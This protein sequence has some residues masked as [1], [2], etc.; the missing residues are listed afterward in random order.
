M[1]FLMNRFCSV[2]SHHS[3]L[4][5]RRSAHPANANGIWCLPSQIPTYVMIKGWSNRIYMQNWL[6]TDLLFLPK[7]HFSVNSNW[8]EWYE[9]RA[10]FTQLGI[11]IKLN[12][13]LLHLTAG[14]PVP[15]PAPHRKALSHCHILIFDACVERVRHNPRNVARIDYDEENCRRTVNHDFDLGTFWWTDEYS[16]E[17]TYYRDV[18]CGFPG[19]IAKSLAVTKRFAYRV[20]LYDLRVMSVGLDVEVFIHLNTFLFFFRSVESTEVSSIDLWKDE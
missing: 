1:S 10:R 16:N 18:V 6:I 14:H 5:H 4:W 15:Q 12:Y 3:P 13:S 11:G 2:K 19:V 7:Q 17:S 9:V 8:T 20:V